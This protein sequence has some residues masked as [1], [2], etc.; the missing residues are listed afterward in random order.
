MKWTRSDQT[1]EFN[2][3]RALQPRLI[4]SLLATGDGV[5]QIELF[6]MPGYVFPGT[7]IRY[8]GRVVV[9]TGSMAAN[10]LGV[11]FSYCFSG[12]RLQVSDLEVWGD[13]PID[14]VVSQLRS[15]IRET[16]GADA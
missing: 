1:Y 8:G 12:D 2:V 14:F 10:P 6:G 13:I 4:E 7:D 15:L 9:K 3:P 16:V 5:Q 11:E